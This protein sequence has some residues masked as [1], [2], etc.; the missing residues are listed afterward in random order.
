MVSVWW[1]TCQVTAAVW[2]VSAVQPVQPHELTPVC[3]YNFQRE[4]DLDLDGQPDDWVRRQGIEFPPY[5][6]AEIDGSTGVDDLAS[7]KFSANGA[8]AAYYSPLIRI[9]DLHTYFFSGQIR[10]A[11]MKHD[12][13]IIS[14]S[15]LDHKRHRLQRFLSK[16]VL[17]EHRTWVEIKLGPMVPADNV[18]FAVIGCHLAPGSGEIHDIGG[19]V[20]FDNLELGRLPRM[21]LD[22]NFYR[23]FV[24]AGE[25]VEVSCQVSG[26][27]PGHRYELDFRFMDLEN[28]VLQQSLQGLDE[29][30]SVMDERLT[31]FL[32]P[33]LVS[34]QLKPQPPGYYTVYA[35]LLRD[36]SPVASQHTSLVT[37]SLV[38][39]V[40]K[41]GEFGWTLSQPLQEREQRELPQIA[42][43]AGIN[44]LKYPLWSTALDRNPRV[45]VDNA[46]MFDQL[47]GFHIS[48]IALLAEPPPVLRSQFSRNWHG[49]N[50]V[51]SLPPKFWQGSLEPVLARYSSTVR[52]W[53]LGSESDRSFIGSAS[54]PSTLQKVRQEIESI[55][56]NVNLGMAWGFDDGP[57]N[58]ATQF[59]S[60]GSD[61][62]WTPQQLGQL[63]SAAPH[64]LTQRWLLLRLAHLQGTTP[65]ERATTL[66]QL[67]ITARM[68]GADRVFVDDV[69]HDEH[70]LL[71]TDGSPRELFI[72]WRTAALM[73]QGKQYLGQ[74]VFP[75]GSPNAV[76]AGEGQ[77][78]VAIWNPEPTQETLYLGPHVHLID[79]WGTSHELA[80]DP[81]TGESI[82]DAGPIPKFLVDCSEPVARW[83]MATQFEIGRMRSEYGGH[84]DALLVTNTFAQGVSGEV[85]LVLPPEW[86][87]EPRTWSIAA[88]AGEQ[89][90]FPTFLRSPPN[91]S[92]GA[93]LMH[94]DFQITADRPYRFRVYA[95]YTMGLNDITIQVV[96]R[97]L[98]DGRLEI[99]QTV[100]NRT[101]PLEKL[102]FRC[103][104]FVPDSKR[105]KLQITK[106][107]QGSDRKLYYLPNADKYKGQELWLRMEQDGGRRVMNYRWKVGA[108]W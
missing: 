47:S 36:G 67:M 81:N 69:Y 35:M 83:R 66:A 24:S 30:E 100:I 18:R 14:V 29:D 63:L 85:S 93:L 44:W 102:D 32:K 87:A 38:N 61:T 79:I 33:R 22:S 43:Q 48:P 10:T 26:L 82:I 98:P 103:S 54:L 46:Q 65:T 80:R 108:D 42:A 91:A 28:R 62:P 92:L 57:P 13:A 2:S 78:M 101:D 84:E 5:V 45:A 25:P 3:Q 72:P 73:L 68:G 56:R 64:S 27:D 76:F 31:D 17:G 60:I 86:E 20:W 7:L 8:A 15:L 53:Q 37:L 21:E 70:G 94:V 89:L 77:A 6:T 1:L 95:P 34:W 11:G 58:P 106:L 9:D 88:E 71:H 39:H 40:R 12:A 107:G 97:K 16:P 49:V 75:H 96:D 59:V 104:L 23:H 90:R 52:S 51:F 99:E 105:Q 50:E 55:S 74:F 19:S 4:N 41:S